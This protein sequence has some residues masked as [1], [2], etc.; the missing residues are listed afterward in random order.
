MQS[1][2]SSE[3]TITKQLFKLQPSSLKKYYDKTTKTYLYHLKDNQKI[4]LPGNEHS[5]LGLHSKYLVMHVFVDV[6]ENWGVELG[7]TDVGNFK[8]RINITT[9]YGKQ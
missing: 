8:R 4:S 5:E 6:G 9:A 2:V 3:K 7:V 1:I